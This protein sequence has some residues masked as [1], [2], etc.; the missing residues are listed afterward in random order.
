V[1]EPVLA[2]FDLDRRA[3]AV[4]RRL[5]PAAGETGEHTHVALAGDEVIG[6]VTVTTAGDPAPVCADL[7]ALY[8]R[9]SWYGTG[10]AD[11]LVHAALDPAIPCR[12]WVFADAPRAR[13]FYRRHGWVPDGARKFEEF[14]ALAQLRM[15]RYPDP[16]RES[17]G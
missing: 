9:E 1:P 4:A 17:S 8:V 12:L 5:A 15:S 7:E 11:D 3:A 14:T 10:V 6:F 16:G 2:A 13:A